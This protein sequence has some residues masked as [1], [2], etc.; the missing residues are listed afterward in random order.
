V[1]IP[2]VCPSDVLG[3][4]RG[5]AFSLVAG[6]FEE[7]YGP[8]H[9]E[10]GTPAEGDQEGQGQRGRWGGVVTCFFM[11]CV[12]VTERAFLH[13]ISPPFLLVHTPSPSH[14]IFRP[15]GQNGSTCIEELTDQARNVLNY[16]RII[17][18][19]VEDGGIWI[20][21]GEPPPSTMSIV[22]LMV[23]GP[24]LWHFENAPTNSAKGEGSIELSLDEVKDLARIVGFEIHVSCRGH[25]RWGRDGTDTG[26]TVQ[27][28]KSVATTYTG[29]PESMLRHEYQVSNSTQSP[30][31]VQ[32]TLMRLQAAFW[33]ATKR[34]AEE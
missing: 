22:V 13:P 33:T 32:L 27:D 25:S 11:D 29:I 5:G 34:K 18:T 30:T 31:E 3:E 24:L 9:W 17:H 12:S 16:L 23:P 19:L 21:I 4:G 8:E 1:G 28:E 7:V 2:D 14:S 10:A 15:A 6:D 20:N 26:A